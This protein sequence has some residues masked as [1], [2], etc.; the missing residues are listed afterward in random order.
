MRRAAAGVLAFVWVANGLFAKLL[1]LVPRHQLIVARFF[2]DAHA[3]ALTRLIGVAEIVMA[4]WIV[5]GWRR[6]WC[7]VTQALVIISMNS[8]ELW[9]ARDLLLAPVL[10]PVGN[11]LLLLLAFWWSQ[12]D[13][14]AA[15]VAQG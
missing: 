14:P 12:A 8:L 15:P 5:S 7:A 2:G 11:A 13:A 4:V 1:G 6:R 3:L 10:M 9:R